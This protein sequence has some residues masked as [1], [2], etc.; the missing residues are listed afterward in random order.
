[1]TTNETKKMLISKV[2]EFV[3]KNKTKYSQAEIE[4][5][6]QNA[7][8]GAYGFYNSAILRQIYA[9][10]DLIPPEKNLYLGFINLLERSF[11]INQNIIEVGGGYIP[12]LSE[13]LALKQKQGTIT[14]YDPKLLTTETNIPNLILKKEKFTENTSLEGIGLQIACMPCEATELTI[15]KACENNIDFMIALCSG[16]EHEKDNYYSYDYDS[17]LEWESRMICTAH[18]YVQKYGLGQLNEASLKDY[19]SLYPV[20]YNKR[21]TQLK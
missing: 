3:E 17:E 12:K 8:C 21:R 14:V 19:G 10:L 6:R 4:Y 13:Y 20:L 7:G 1:M 5:I 18:E 9:E 2:D 16:S 11:D 15:K